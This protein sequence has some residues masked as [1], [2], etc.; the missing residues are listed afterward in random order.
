MPNTDDR[1]GWID[2]AK[3]VGI[4]LVIAGHT[5]W[6]GWSW[7][8]YSFHLP[9]FF[10]ISG[11][12]SH[13]KEITSISRFLIKK[14]QA[15]IAPWCI[16]VFASVTVC[17]L[18]PEWRNGLHVAR[19][20]RDIYS[21]NLN[22]IQNS[23]LWYLPCLLATIVLFSVFV[24][25]WRANRRMGLAMLFCAFVLS[26]LFPKILP[27]MRFLPGARLPLKIDTAILGF[28]FFVVGWLLVEKSLPATV[29]LWRYGGMAM[30]FALAVW[31]LGAWTNG[32]VN[33]NSLEYG[34]Y[35]ILY[36]PVA[37]CGIFVVCLISRFL[38][39]DSVLGNV[40]SFYG[41]NTLI[42][43]CSQSLFIRIYLLVVGNVFGEKLVLYGRNPLKHQVLSFIVV[44]FIASPL[45]VVVKGVFSRM[46]KR[47]GKDRGNA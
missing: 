22:C 7:P 39:R 29:R 27:L 2:I 13:R 18:I 15:L 32:W 28:C 3:G 25:I 24:F 23:S 33:M 4:L 30:F 12:L 16:A 40:L 26:M 14:A 10:F 17:A 47:L 6:L 46:S 5:F 31:G 36:M 43:F 1:V 11:I 45:L 41:K 20:V 21:A 42:I 35:P 19:I 38:P 44:A 8:V 37:F 34:K 9:L